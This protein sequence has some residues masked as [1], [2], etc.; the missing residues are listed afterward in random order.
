MVDRQKLE[1][2]LSIESFFDADECIA[3]GFADEI[4]EPITPQ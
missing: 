2:I 3:Y 4:I 1:D